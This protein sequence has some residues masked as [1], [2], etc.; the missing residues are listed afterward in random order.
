MLSEGPK[1]EERARNIESKDM[2]ESL[3]VFDEKKEI[4]TQEEEFVKKTMTNYQHTKHY[5]KIT[6]DLNEKCRDIIKAINYNNDELLVVDKIDALKKKNEIENYFNNEFDDEKILDNH[7]KLS[8]FLFKSKEASVVVTL[9]SENHEKERQETENN[10]NN[11]NQKIALLKNDPP[12]LNLQEKFSRLIGQNNRLSHHEMQIDNLYIDKSIENIRLNNISQKQEQLKSLQVQQNNI[13]ENIINDLISR[14][15]K[16]MSRQIIQD[17]SISYHSKKLFDIRINQIIQE[18]IIDRNAIDIKDR[19]LLKIQRKISDENRSIAHDLKYDQGNS[20]IENKSKD[21]QKKFIEKFPALE[22]SINYFIEQKAKQ[23][24]VKLLNSLSAT[25]KIDFDKIT[26]Y[27]F[28]DKKQPNFREKISKIS[29]DDYEFRFF[30]NAVQNLSNLDL[31]SAN[32]QI[33]L[34]DTSI[35]RYEQRLEKYYDIDYLLGDKNFKKTNFISNIILKTDQKNLAQANKIEKEL[36]RLYREKEKIINQRKQ[37]DEKN[38]QRIEMVNEVL[39]QNKNKIVDETLAKFSFSIPNKSGKEFNDNY[40]IFENFI[41]DKSSNIILENTVLDEKKANNVAINKI[42]SDNLNKPENE[43]SIIEKRQW[44]KDLNESKSQELQKIKQRLFSL[45]LKSPNPEQQLLQIESIYERNNLPDFAKKFKIF[46]TIYLQPHH[47]EKYANLF[48]EEMYESQQVNVLGSTE[49]KVKLSP[50]LNQINQL[51]NGKL[52]NAIIAD[53]FYKDL[54]KINIKSNNSSLK[55]NLVLL[56]RGQKLFDKFE[57]NGQDSLSKEE[58]TEISSIFNKLDVLYEN[59]LL[60]QRQQEHKTQNIDKNDIGNRISA[61]KQDLKVE[62]NQTIKDRIFAMFVEPLGY[63]SLEDVIKQMDQIKNTVHERNI[64]QLKNIQL[65][66]NNH[67]VF[68]NNYLIKGMGDGTF[69]YFTQ[70][71]GP[72]REFMGLQSSSDMTP[73]DS[74]YFLVSHKNDQSD[75]DDLFKGAKKYATNFI[76]NK[77]DNNGVVLIIRNRQQF[78]RTDQFN[79][80]E[81]LL[82]KEINNARKKSQQSDKY[83]LFQTGYWGKDHFGVR[84]GMPP[85]EIDVVMCKKEVIQDNIRLD[86]VFHSI[87]NNGYYIP[88][89]NEDGKIIFTPEDFAK[90]QLNS[91]VVKESLSDKNYEPAK[92]LSNLAKSPFIKK[93]YNVSSGVKEGYS[94]GQHTEMVL[95]QFEKY[96]HNKDQVKIISRE[97]FK[98][99]LALHD[100]GKGL[101]NI[102]KGNTDEQHEYTKKVLWNTL[103]SLD[104]EANKID[105]VIN[106]IDQDIVGDFI[107]ESSNA[108]RTNEKLQDN[109]KFSLEIK[110]LAKAI[111]KDPKDTLL[112]L[113]QFYFCDAGSYTKDAG[114]QESLDEIFDFEKSKNKLEATFSEKYEEKFSNLM[115]QLS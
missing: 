104:M 24:S 20:K 72:S 99:V 92:L 35:K 7:Q 36:A 30:V 46:E 109:N 63:K 1:I 6:S 15:K 80:N 9:L 101:A 21:I 82:K 98:L 40:E 22:D 108:I 2:I 103:K 71:G 38:I 67:F 56:Q 65:F 53:T 58:L 76:D 54:L 110:K 87:A 29:K 86:K 11:I 115:S 50:V 79:G 52:K 16:E 28:F 88:V 41:K 12:I 33:K 42:I 66:N 44:M 14:T 48:E 31:E 78:V 70:E 8:E 59:S 39:L 60:Y 81:D 49:K 23:S 90:Y 68:K 5:E 105:L 47:H 93:L 112:L 43:E 106:L 94:V 18:N 96:F 27:E 45:L 114:G 57:K 64:A 100:I 77:Q 13:S 26:E 75:I 17:N 51:K 10:I 25:D 102:E 62:E 34:L 107:K 61:F 83:E 3:A 113:K 19:H 55:N 89:I 91:Q 97:E 32:N 4:K 69:D 85:T 37:Y 111:G 84:T 74:D 73:F 95:N